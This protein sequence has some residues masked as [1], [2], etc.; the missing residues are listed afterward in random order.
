MGSRL[1]GVWVLGTIIFAGVCVAQE[2][3]GV[4]I[5]GRALDSGPAALVLDGVVCGPLA[6]AARLASARADWNKAE[7]TLT[8][9]TAR[10]QSVKLAV[11]SATAQ[12][13][14]NPRVLPRK[15]ELRQGTCYGPLEPVLTALG[16]SFRWKKGDAFVLA[17]AVLTQVE[18]RADARGARIRL[19]CSAPVTGNTERMAAPTRFYVDLRGAEIAPDVPMIQYI[20]TG[21]L[22]RVRLGVPVPQPP[23]ARVVADL[24]SDQPG[25][26][27]PAAGGYGGIMIIGSPSDNA[28]V[29]KRRFPA[30]T[31][32]TLVQGTD[33][34][35]RL[36]I[37]TDWPVTPNW[38]LHMRPV[39]I[40]VSFAD[41]RSGTSERD[42]PMFGEFVESVTVDQ[43]GDPPQTTLTLNLRELIQFDVNPIAPAGLEIVFRREQLEGKR[44][45]LDA[46]HGG[47]DNGA[48]G[49]VLK[50]KEVTLDVAQ[51]AARILRSRGVLARM[52]R[53][54][55]RFVDLY[56][57]AGFANRLG[58]DMFVSIH[59][60]AMPRRNE[61]IGTETFYYR[62]ASK[63][64][65]MIMQ[66]SLVA[67]LKRPDRGLKQA[68]FVVIRETR[69]PAVLV[70]LMFLN[71]DTEEALLQQDTTRER[72]AVAICE[73]LRQFV[74]GTGAPG[75]M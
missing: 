13:A 36:R 30:I 40:T 70:E 75:R 68:R 19:D 69:M 61:G 14:G 8:L 33:D 27:E 21:P 50:E 59:C 26:W 20:H 51:R 60:N 3:V 11:G 74:E 39:R 62:Q 52:T 63:C 64:L 58:A 38:D 73:G 29:V 22:A 7:Q 16:L 32:V 49:K 37:L 4:V 15:I 31:D 18:V 41:T 65:G 35:E 47:K 34:S 6:D 25:R 5:C 24:G 44:V 46:G 2:P 9:T 1:G 53:D 12:I 17:N 54:D 71:S 28:P 55:D 67:A 66:Q 23:T 42:L 43:D 56:D 45:V 72:A 48:S 10:G 57:R